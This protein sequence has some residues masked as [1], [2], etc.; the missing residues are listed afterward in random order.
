[1]AMPSSAEHLRVTGPV[2]TMLPGIIVGTAVV[3]AMCWLLIGR[4]YPAVGDAAPF[5]VAVLVA[6]VV[7]TWSVRLAAPAGRI[8][9]TGLLG[10]AFLLLVSLGFTVVAWEIG[11][12][13]HFSLGYCALAAVGS[14]LFA[15]RP[16]HFVGGLAA[17]LVPPVVFVCAHD[18]LDP[19]GRTV[20]LLFAAITAVVSTALYLVLRQ[21]NGRA[22]QQALDIQ[23]QASHDGLT[24]I[25]NRSGWLF[26]A[27]N[28]V[29]ASERRGVPVTLLV[30]DID[31]FKALNDTWGHGAGDRLLV[32]L[33]DVLRRMAGPNGLAGRMG[34][35]E[36]LVLLPEETAE[37]AQELSE[38]A[39][40]ALDE[41]M[42]GQPATTFSVGIT[43]RED[44]ET[45]ATL[46]SRADRRMYRDKQN[47]RGPARVVALFGQYDGDSTDEGPGSERR[48]IRHPATGG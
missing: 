45:L 11:Q 21:A 4:L 15:L 47:G 26:E 30:V 20:A 38:W 8:E 42:A 1:M 33:A 46:I 48:S 13:V 2:A 28:R 22:D 36:F 9:L 32:G 34:G 23:H 29:I 17:A 40:V 25:A 7:L 18:A 24:G 41:V 43:E 14:V 35:D 44:G 5:L 12:G 19:I 3:S 6:L 10:I 39:R 37:S 16:W 31:A 27:E